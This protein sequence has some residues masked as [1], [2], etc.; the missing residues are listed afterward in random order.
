[1]AKIDNL[2]VDV[3]NLVQVRFC[4]FSNCHCWTTTNKEP[5]FRESSPLTVWPTSETKPPR[6]RTSLEL[7][8]ISSKLKI[9]TERLHEIKRPERL[10]T[11]NCPVCGIR[12]WI[13]WLVVPHRWIQF[14]RTFSESFFYYCYRRFSQSFIA[15]MLEQ[16]QQIGT[17]KSYCCLFHNDVLTNFGKDRWQ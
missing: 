8:I 12:V 14:Q 9:W 13:P 6:S 3:S 2:A 7:R 5:L 11:R 17:L 10:A 1:M 16:P 15:V 4:G